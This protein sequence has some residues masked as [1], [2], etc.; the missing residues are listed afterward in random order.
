MQYVSYRTHA[1]LSNQY[2]RVAKFVVVNVQLKKIRMDNSLP[3]WNSTGEMFIFYNR[4]LVFS[5][6]NVSAG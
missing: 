2:S 5:N 6:L 1:D 4:T 3:I